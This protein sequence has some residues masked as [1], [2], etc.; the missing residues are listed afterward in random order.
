MVPFIL[1]NG[2]Q[3]HEAWFLH[4]VIREGGDHVLYHPIITMLLG[5]SSTFTQGTGYLM[6]TKDSEHLEVICFSSH[7]SNKYCKKGFSFL[8]L[9]YVNE[10]PKNAA[11]FLSQFMSFRVVKE[12]QYICLRRSQRGGCGLSPRG[13]RK[14]GASPGMGLSTDFPTRCGSALSPPCAFCMSPSLT[15]PWKLFILVSVPKK[16]SMHLFWG[17]NV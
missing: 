17:K 9:K 10:M 7:S 14:A 5:F 16:V 2:A 6:S 13:L 3:L 1:G 12:K 4:S 11:W 8:H 15:Q